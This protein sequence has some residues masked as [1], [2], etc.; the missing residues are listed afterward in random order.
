MPIGSSYGDYSRKGMEV[1][2]NETD[3]AYI[4]FLNPWVVIQEH[5]IDTLIDRINVPDNAPA[6]CG[7]DVNK[8]LMQKNNE[9]FDAAA[10]EFNKYKA[11]APDE[12]M[13]MNFNFFGMS[14]YIAEM[15]PLDPVIKTQPYLERDFFQS[16]G[17][18]GYTA[19]SSERVPIFGF[20]F[21][22]GKYVK[23]TD[24]EDDKAAFLKK[25]KFLP[26]NITHD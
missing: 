2:L 18:K 10:V 12:L 13:M 11:N 23:A 6:I 20:Q 14:R 19:V 7:Y 16:M 1:A 21:D 24:Y 17:S 22:W 5:G 15:C 4:I 3:G 8:K 9:N 26:E 25:W